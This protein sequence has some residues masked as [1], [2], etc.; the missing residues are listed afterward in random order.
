MPDLHVGQGG[1]GAIDCELSWRMQV[2]EQQ[3][4][5][6]GV[7]ARLYGQPG[8]DLFPWE[9]TAL[10]ACFHQQVGHGHAEHTGLLVSHWLKGHGT[11]VEAW[12]QKVKVRR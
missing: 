3:L 5:L 1:S 6:V 10:H 7:E 11:C 4:I 2:W 8:A 12:G 9:C